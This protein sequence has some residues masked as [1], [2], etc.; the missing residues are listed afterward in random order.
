MPSLFCHLTLMTTPLCQRRYISCGG[1]AGIRNSLFAICLIM[2]NC[3]IKYLDEFV[4]GGNVVLVKKACWQLPARINELF[5]IWSEVIP[6]FWEARLNMLAEITQ[7]IVF[8]MGK[9]LLWAFIK[10]SIH[11]NRLLFRDR[12]TKHGRAICVCADCKD[13]V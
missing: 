11:W 2:A 1:D 9:F 10:P 6:I 13:G 7:G 12:E 5:Q 8:L 4:M 3:D